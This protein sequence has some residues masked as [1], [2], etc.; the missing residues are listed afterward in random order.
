M[1]LS[2]FIKLSIPMSTM[3]CATSNST[4]NLMQHHDV[5]YMAIWH[6]RHIFPKLHKSPGPSLLSVPIKAER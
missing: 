2:I 1:D 6:L 5:L 4:S 3:V